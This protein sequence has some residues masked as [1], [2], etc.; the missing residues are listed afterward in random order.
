MACLTGRLNSLSLDSWKRMRPLAR[1]ERCLRV[2][3][4]EAFRL[5][6]KHEPDGLAAGDLARLLSVPQ[7]TLS[8]H[9]NVLACANLVT[10]ER[11]GRSII[12]RVQLGRLEKLLLFLLRDCCNGRPDIRGQVLETIMRLLPI[13]VRGR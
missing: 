4:L 10:S 9:L 7:N 12:Y 13:K 5:L 3:R 6:V 11:Q 8:A 2:T 1:S